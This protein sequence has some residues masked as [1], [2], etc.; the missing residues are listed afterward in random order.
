M[1]QNIWKYI[2]EWWQT[3]SRYEWWT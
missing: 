2:Y 1:K 3:G